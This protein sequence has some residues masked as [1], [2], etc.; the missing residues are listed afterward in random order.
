[1]EALT[2]L[3]RHRAELLTAF[4]W[5]L[6]WLLVTAGVDRHSLWLGSVGLLCISL[7]GWRL[8]WIVLTHGLYTLTR[9]KQ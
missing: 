8:L 7:G 6:G 4:A 9:E 2:W 3:R 5:L 1:M